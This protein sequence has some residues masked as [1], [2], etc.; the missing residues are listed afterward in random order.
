MNKPVAFDLVDEQSAEPLYEQVAQS[1]RTYIRSGTLSPGDQLPSARILSES[2]GVNELTVRR[3]IKKLIRNGL[4][5]SRQGK[6]VFATPK[7][8]SRHILW[9]HG[10]NSFQIFNNYY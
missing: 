1:I 10:A 2:F 9:M 4:L 3:G 6:G 8:C 7:A 5:Y